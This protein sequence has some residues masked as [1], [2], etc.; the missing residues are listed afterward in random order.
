MIIYGTYNRFQFHTILSDVLPTLDKYHLSLTW[1]L[2]DLECTS[3]PEFLQADEPIIITG[4][5]LD[6]VMKIHPKL[7][8][9]WGVLS[10]FRLSPEEID[11]TIIPFAE[12]SKVWEN[13]YEIQ[14]PQAECELVAWDSSATFFRSKNKKVMRIFSRTFPEAKTLETFNFGDV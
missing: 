1:M 14:H 11:Q 13:E 12:G 10:G 7:Q 4:S 5:E 6:K 3:C 8:I 2:S 9:I